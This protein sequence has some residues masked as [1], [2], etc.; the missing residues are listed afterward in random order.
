MM[1][2]ITIFTIFF[3][4]F[5][6]QASCEN[7]SDLFGLS[8]FIELE[9]E[10]S[11]VTAP[12]FKPVLDVTVNLDGAGNFSILTDGNGSLTGVQFYY[13]NGDKPEDT[14]KIFLTV[15]QFNKGETLSYTAS[16]FPG[17]AT[18]VKVKPGTQLNKTSGGDFLFQM[19][20]DVDPNK[21]QDI[22]FSLKKVNGV[23]SV[24]YNNKPA[25]SITLYPETEW[26]VSWTGSFS[27]FVVK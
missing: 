5:L 6:A 13:K 7:S 1:K 10:S 24:Y 14:T 26:L 15:E 3:S 25:K 11:T 9:Q 21:Y 19:R 12:L 8:A 17:P 22:N 2:L 27:K 20:K 4:T 18:I 23:W 16:D